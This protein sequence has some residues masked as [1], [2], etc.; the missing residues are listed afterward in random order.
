M[1]FHGIFPWKPHE[2]DQ[3]QHNGK[4]RLIEGLKRVCDGLTHPVP[5]GTELEE[6][7]LLQQ[8]LEDGI[9]F[10]KSRPIGEPKQIGSAI[11]NFSSKAAVADF[12]R[13]P[14]LLGN[15][16]AEKAL[17]IL[18]C[19]LSKLVQMRLVHSCGDLGVFIDGDFLD[20]SSDRR[21]IVEL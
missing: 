5:F 9:V 8:E 10:T 19:H 1:H 4:V 17:E 7:I 6:G 14:C 18:L 16:D 20:G 11:M 12:N 13:H 3:E 21:L 15:A 2:Y